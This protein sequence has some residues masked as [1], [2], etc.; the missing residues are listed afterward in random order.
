MWRSRIALTLALLILLISVVRAQDVRPVAYLSLIT[1]NGIPELSTTP[2][3]TV[4]PTNMATSTPIPVQL[5]PN[6]DFEQGKTVWSPQENADAIIIQNPPSPVVPRSGSWVAET[7]TF[8]SGAAAI[9]SP[10]VVVQVRVSW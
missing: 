7:I 6:G 10:D 1:V 2:T 9:D 5:L 8:S 4:T 3:R